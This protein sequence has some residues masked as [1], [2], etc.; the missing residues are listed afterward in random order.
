MEFYILKRS[1]SRDELLFVGGVAFLGVT[2][3]SS[4]DNLHVMRM[5]FSAFLHS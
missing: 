2:A 5:A 4:T 3:G 1:L